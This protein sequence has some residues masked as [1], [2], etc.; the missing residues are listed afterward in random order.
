MSDE[1]VSPSGEICLRFI[2]LSLRLEIHWFLGRERRTITM[3]LHKF[4]CVYSY[5]NVCMYYFFITSGHH[6]SAE[7]SADVAPVEASEIMPA[8]PLQFV[9]CIHICKYVYVLYIFLTFGHDP[10]AELSASVA[11]VEAFGIMRIESSQV[12][13]SIYT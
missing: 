13:M 10:S 4:Q 7:L 11:P 3:F 12:P 9:I 1:I 2:V 8:E 5:L 6:R